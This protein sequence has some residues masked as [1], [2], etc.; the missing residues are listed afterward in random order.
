MFR[1]ALTDPPHKLHARS[2]RLHGDLHE[3]EQVEQ[4]LEH[5]QQN[6]EHIKTESQQASAAKYSQ[7]TKQRRVRTNSN[8]DICNNNCAFNTF[9]SNIYHLLSTAAIVSPLTATA[10]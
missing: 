3:P 9:N 7:Q 4:Q 6:Q 5:Q 8:I 10:K 2:G 1:N